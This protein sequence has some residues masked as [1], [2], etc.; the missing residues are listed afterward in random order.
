[1]TVN[2][3]ENSACPLSLKEHRKAGMIIG[4]AFAD[5]PVNAWVF[6]NERGIAAYFSL[7]ARKLYLRD[8]FGHSTGDLGATLWL[9][10]RVHKAFSILA[11]LD[12]GATITWN[13]GLGALLRG[14]H[15][16]EGFHA[17]HPKEPHFYLYAIGVRPEAQGKGLGGMLMRAGLERVDE[18]GAA[19][20]LESTKESNV[21]L[22]RRFGF[23]VREPFEPTPGC[24]P[25]W[26]MWRPAR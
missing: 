21:P 7:I 11:S 12:I 2:V 5:D 10:P 3:S 24:P 13:S 15:V 26:P 14:M 1:M 16:D 17:H 25:V 19:A 23:E 18:A 22:Y 6:G 20:Y 4:A 8:G 9:P